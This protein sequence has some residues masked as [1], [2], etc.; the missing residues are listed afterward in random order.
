L[1]SISQT[2][3]GFFCIEWIS[4]EQGPKIVNLEHLK[5]NIDFSN[6]NDLET[7]LKLYKSNVKS[8]SKSLSIILNAN[9]LLI[10]KIELLDS[11]D[12]S[13]NIIDWHELNILGKEFCDNNYNFYFPIHSDNSHEYLSIYLPKKIKDNIVKS[14]VDLGYEL[15]YLS[16]DI[17]S[18]AIGA[19]QV[20]YNEINNEYLVWKICNKNLHRLVLYNKNKLNA[21]IEIVKKNNRFIT[22]KYI[23]SKENENLL[24]NCVNEILIN[25]S[26]FHRFNNIYVYQTKQNKSDINRIID[27]NFKNIKI[28]NFNN[29][30]DR[31]KEY[32]P[33]K[34]I[35][36]VENGIVFKGID[37]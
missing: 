16:I 3:R 13:M 31:T 21:Y 20:F 29:M 14:S 7:I 26:N 36:F 22:K 11:I 25:K 8:N 37:I 27:L 24:I 28:L 30:I 4:T 17:F 1:L 18:A 33:L 10:S 23:G 6:K 12:K 2:S 19:R 5:L 32:N 34:Y 15:R 9:K 35:S